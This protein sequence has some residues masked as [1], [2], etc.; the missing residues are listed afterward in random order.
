MQPPPYLVC[1]PTRERINWLSGRSPVTT[2]LPQWVERLVTLLP[3]RQ[4]ADLA[5][6]HWHTFKTID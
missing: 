4:V 3:I 1:G 2:T 6:L 5:G